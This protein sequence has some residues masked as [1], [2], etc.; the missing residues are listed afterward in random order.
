MASHVGSG[1][2]HKASNH[3]SSVKKNVMEIMNIIVLWNTDNVHHTGQ[4]GI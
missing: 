3:Y 2:F 4:N 1:L